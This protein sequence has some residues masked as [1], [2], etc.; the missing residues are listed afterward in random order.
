M[1]YWFD[2]GYLG[3]L[4]VLGV[5]GVLGASAAMHCALTWLSLLVVL[6]AYSDVLVIDTTGYCFITRI[7]A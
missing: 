3:D 2:A 5:L 6:V 1:P 4:G 7:L